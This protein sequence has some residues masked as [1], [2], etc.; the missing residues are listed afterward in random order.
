MLDQILNARYDR[1]KEQWNCPSCKSKLGKIDNVF[2]AMGLPIGYRKQNEN[3]VY[4]RS[5]AKGRFAGPQRENR[6]MRQHMRQHMTQVQEELK[7][8][9]AAK[10]FQP[11]TLE[12]N[13]PQCGPCHVSANQFPILVECP[14]LQCKLKSKIPSLRA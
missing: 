8:F 11:S 2:S 1:E 3:N 5:E 13:T 6:Q 9:R 14:N 7:E 10:G 4:V 12:V